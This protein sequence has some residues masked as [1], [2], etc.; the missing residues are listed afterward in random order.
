MIDLAEYAHRT[1]IAALRAEFPGAEAVE[2]EDRAFAFVAIA[3]ARR[4]PLERLFDWIHTRAPGKEW[5]ITEWRGFAAAYVRE[6]E[7]HTQDLRDAGLRAITDDLYG[8][9][10]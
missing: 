9:V 8:G 5:S 10:R 4:I 2:L 1:V 3:E 7:Q 6:R